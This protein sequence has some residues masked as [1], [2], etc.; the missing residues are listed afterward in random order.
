M[1]KAT[2]NVSA[3]TQFFSFG[4]MSGF[5]ILSIVRVIYSFFNPTIFTNLNYPLI[6][7]I[8]GIITALEGS[9]L[10]VYQVFRKDKENISLTKIIIYMI[11]TNI[12]L[13]I[14]GISISISLNISEIESFLTTKDCLG[15]S[16]MQIINLV[17]TSYLCFTSK[18]RLSL[19]RNNS[20]KLLDLRYVGKEFPLTS[21]VLIISLTSMIGLLPTFGGVNL[22]MMIF[23]LIQLR[24]YAFTFVI[25][26]IIVLLI[27]CYLIVLKYLL[28]DKHSRNISMSGGL[29]DDLTLPNFFGLIVAVG[30]IILGLIPNIIASKIVDNALF[31]IT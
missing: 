4:I 21:I 7:S 24:F 2:E 14:T 3:S 5:S 13:I 8:I 18:E 10:L 28:F 17:I 23:S 6:F 16:L 22:Y 20:D 1:P 31:I 26:L 15:Y 9:F 11:F 12:G 25:V 27:I 29:I 19:N 30:L